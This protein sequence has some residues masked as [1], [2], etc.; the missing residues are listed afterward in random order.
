M[1]DLHTEAMATL[2][3]KPPPPPRRI[4]LEGFRILLMAEIAGYH[5][6]A[7]RVSAPPAH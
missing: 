3:P 1:N 2:L 4:N 6:R 7:F 5:L